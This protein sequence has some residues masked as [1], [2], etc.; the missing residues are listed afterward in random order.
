MSIVKWNLASSVTLEHNLEMKSIVYDTVDEWGNAPT[1]A[2]ENSVPMLREVKLLCFIYYLQPCES[3]R[4]RNCSGHGICI[5]HVPARG[6]FICECEANWNGMYCEDGGETGPCTGES[7]DACGA[8]GDCRLLAKL[9]PLLV[10]VCSCKR[11][12]TGRRCQN[13]WPDVR[14][15]YFTFKYHNAITF[16]ANA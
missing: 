6:Q 16:N 8:N 10:M 1:A 13:P 12:W 14:L 9:R 3:S 5:P 4:S 7:D 2:K 15:Q 11:G